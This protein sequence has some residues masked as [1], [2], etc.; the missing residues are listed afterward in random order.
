M[1]SEENLINQIEEDNPKR[2]FTQACKNKNNHF[3]GK[4]YGEPRIILIRIILLS[5]SNNHIEFGEYLTPY[6]E[7]IID[8][9]I[10]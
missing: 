2:N 8:L 10:Q 4:T 1:S 9:M 3:R 7:R 5:Y 6:K